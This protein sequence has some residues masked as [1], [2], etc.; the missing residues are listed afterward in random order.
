[1]PARR[2]AAGD[3]TKP[4]SPTRQLV[5]SLADVSPMR[6][7]RTNAFRS[8]LA[9]L[10]G[11]C[12]IAGFGASHVFAADEPRPPLAI[13]F[14]LD[15][16]IDAAAAPFV[17]AA[18]GGLFS[19]EALA[20]TTNIAS[21]S[22]DAIARV[23]AGHQR[24]RAGRH[25]RADALSRQGQAGRP[26]DQGGLR[27]VQQGALRHHRPQEPGHSGAVGYRRQDSRRCRRRSVDPAVAR[28]GQAERHQ[29]QARQTEQH[30]RRGARADAV[31]RPDRRRHRIFLSVRDQSEG[32]RRACRR[33]GGAE[34][35]RLWLR[36]LWF[37]RHRQSG[38]GGRQA[39]GGKGV[40]AGRRS[41]ACIWR[42]RTPAA[43][44]PKS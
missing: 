14:S 1:M 41:A 16:P 22:S 10:A 29:D 19:A 31:G 17:M 40:R 32:P 7:T 21:G 42:S 37:R 5:P 33:S 24:F 20:V 26:Q 34:I 28:G 27:A 9:S 35:R 25:Q 13:Q 4:A 44:R 43:P 23:A 36:G 39:R 3:V 8:L 12:G 30:Q 18:A 11:L 38:T 6:T 2:L 15:R